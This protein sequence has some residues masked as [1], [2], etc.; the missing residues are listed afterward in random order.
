VSE[1]L[2]LE[3]ERRE[4]PPTSTDLFSSA[5]NKT[6]QMTYKRLAFILTDDQN[7][8]VT[9]HGQQVKGTATLLYLPTCNTTSLGTV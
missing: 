4:V 2:E 8:H 5:I 1:L 3:A 6:D 9:A 7:L